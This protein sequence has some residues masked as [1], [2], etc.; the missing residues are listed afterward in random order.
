MTPSESYMYSCN[1][2]YFVVLY[3]H[4]DQARLRDYYL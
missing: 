3:G 1:S 4:R 2:H